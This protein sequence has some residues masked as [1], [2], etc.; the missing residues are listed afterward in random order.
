MSK[1]WCFD[2]LQDAIGIF[3][4]YKNSIGIGG[5]E[6]RITNNISYPTTQ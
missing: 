5:A 4:Y 3:V 1:S 6:R 2:K